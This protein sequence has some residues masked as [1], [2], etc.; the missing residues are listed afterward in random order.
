MENEPDAELQIQSLEV[1]AKE[2]LSEEKIKILKKIAYYTSRVGLSLKE[3]CILL[4][5]N[6][7]SFKKEMKSSPVI[8]RIIAIKELEYKKDLLL[9][10]STKA[11]KDGDSKLAQWL[12]S[13]KYPKE[14][15]D[16]K[17]REEDTGKNVIAEALKLIRV[18]GDSAPLVNNLPQSNPVVLSKLAQPKTTADSILS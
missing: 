18:K 3:S 8:G 2:T 13:K 6:F 17:D 11:V 4:N 7:E 15:G 12:L 10:I 9:T 16:R 5:V 14:Y 1:Q